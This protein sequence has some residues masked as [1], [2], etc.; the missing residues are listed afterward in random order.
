MMYQ[1]R[2]HHNDMRPE[3]FEQPD[4]SNDNDDDKDNDD[5]EDNGDTEMPGDADVTVFVRVPAGHL[6]AV[7]VNAMDTIIMVKAIIQDSIPYG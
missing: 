4:R 2:Q 7:A 1:D 5:E 3:D 6:V